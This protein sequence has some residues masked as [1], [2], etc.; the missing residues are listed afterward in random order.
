MNGNTLRNVSNPVNPQDVATKEYADKVVNDVG[1]YADEK[2]A[3]IKREVDDF[4]KLLD[5]VK[6]TI[7]ERPHIIA[8]IANYKG[9]LRKDEYHFAF[10]GNVASRLDSGFLVQQ[11]GHIKK[12]KVKVSFGGKGFFLKVY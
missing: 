3:Y 5:Y 1:K 10:G 7:D 6:K 4:T 12:I 2:N 8:V 11:S 9:E